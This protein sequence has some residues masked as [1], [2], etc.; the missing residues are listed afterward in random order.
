MLFFLNLFKIT[1]NNFYKIIFLAKINFYF[2]E[3][4]LNKVIIKKRMRIKI[5]IKQYTKE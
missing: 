3:S 2:G 1:K 5:N 4:I